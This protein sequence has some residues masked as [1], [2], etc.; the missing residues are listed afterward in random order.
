MADFGRTSVDKTSPS[1]PDHELPAL[2]FPRNIPSPPPEN[3]AAGSAKGPRP[4]TS[5]GPLPGTGTGTATGAGAEATD[6]NPSSLPDGAKSDASQRVKDV[7]GS[8]V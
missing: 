7:M 3:G 6:M 5:T 2:T 4:G 8:E 1:Q